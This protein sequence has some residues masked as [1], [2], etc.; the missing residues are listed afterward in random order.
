VKEIPHED[1]ATGTGGLL[2]SY[3]GAEPIT[4]LA[5][6]ESLS[7]TRWTSCDSF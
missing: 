6:R 4:E 7:P 3:K 1:I 2:K 5:M